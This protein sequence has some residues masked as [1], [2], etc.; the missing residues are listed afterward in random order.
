[1]RHNEPTAEQVK[2][3]IEV[4]LNFGNRHCDLPPVVTFRQRLAETFESGWVFTRTADIVQAVLAELL[5]SPELIFEKDSVVRTVTDAEMDCGSAALVEW[6]DDDE[7]NNGFIVNDYLR[8]SPGA[9]RNVTDIFNL[10]QDAQRWHFERLA[11]AAFDAI[12][13]TI[14]SIDYPN[15]V[16]LYTDGQI[17]KAWRVL[18]MPGFDIRVNHDH[19]TVYVTY[20]DTDEEEIAYEVVNA[21]GPGTH[22]GIA[23]EQL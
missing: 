12:R 20:I 4:L 7:F 13:D 9:G 5:H 15:P 21:T 2:A 1:M 16:T 14:K 10:I 11:R 23:F 18:N 22:N 17:I 6:L 3:T 19:D 8:D